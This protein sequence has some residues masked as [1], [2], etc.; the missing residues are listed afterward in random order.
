MPSRKMFDNGSR[1]RDAAE[2]TPPADEGPVSDSA[3][4][5][6]H[7]G[8]HSSYGSTPRF[9]VLAAVMALGMSVVAP[10]FGRAQ[11][12]SAA[13]N[14][15]ADASPP[16]DER[17][18][19]DNVEENAAADKSAESAENAADSKDQDAKTNAGQADLDEAMLKR[20]DAESNKELEAV[21]ALLE[22]ALAKGLDEGNEAFARKMLGSVQFQRGQ[23]LAAAMM[24]ARGRSQIQLRNEALRTLENAVENDPTLVEAYLLIAR[25]NLLPEGDQ[26]AIA[27]ATSK[28]IELLGD[29]PQQQSAAYV[30]RALVQEKIDD[31]LA[32]LDAAIKVDPSNVEALQARAAVRMQADNVDGAVEDLRSILNQDPSNQAVA[33]AAVQQLVDLNRAEDAIDLLSKTLEAQPSEG[34][35]RLRAI[36]YRMQGKED[37][38]LEDLN[39]ALAMQPKDP[40]SL[41]QRAEIALSNNDVQAAKRDL[42]SATEI[43]PQVANSD[44]AILVRCLIAIEEERMADAINAMKLLVERSPDDTFRQLQLATLYMQDER[45]RQAVET[46]SKILDR[47]PKNV[48]AL[49]TRADA[50]LAVGDHAAAVRDYETALSYSEEGD[51]E[52]AGILNNLAWVLA[53]S[54]DE[55]L[56]DGERAVELGEKAAKLTEYSEA[57]ILS[58]LAAGFAESGN[59]EKAIHWAEKAVELGREEEH[60]QI[61]QLENELESYRQNK[62]WREKQETKENELPILAPED[63]IDT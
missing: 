63:L 60:A 21:A 62:P 22:S 28:A 20:I 56:R 35:Y 45:P 59:F 7:S 5:E 24:R 6:S 27:E 53:T 57:H 31:K 54:P 14:S 49:R 40:V 46:L 1:P 26:D 19:N 48:T 8:D 23:G 38:A 10:A 51:P 13:E 17:N 44:Q 32:D 52:N 36:L 25:L 30:L 11:E 55:S 50:L 9:A 42:K 39:K 29:D 4:T 58:T 33:Q 12:V 37:Q 18:N 15:S 61:E 41:L 47:E 3:A 34:L 2:F 16:S 43:S